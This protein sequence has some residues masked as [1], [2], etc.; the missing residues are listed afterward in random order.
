[1][2]IQIDLIYLLKIFAKLKDAGVKIVINT[3]AHRMETLD[4]MKIG[5]S[6]AKKGWIKKSAY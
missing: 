6:T 3:D 2:Q 1:M 4:H 5:V